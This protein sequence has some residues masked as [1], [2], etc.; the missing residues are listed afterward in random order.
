M[1]PAPLRLV[2]PLSPVVPASAAMAVVTRP[3]AVRWLSLSSTVNPAVAGYKPVALAV[4]VTRCGPSAMVLCRTRIGKL[5][6]TAL[7][8]NSDKG[9]HGGFGRVA[10]GERYF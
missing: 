9:G 5:T 7:A 10:A 8:G 6:E 2:V 4:M 3:P 1:P